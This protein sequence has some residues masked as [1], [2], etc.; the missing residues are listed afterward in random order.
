MEFNFLIQICTD[1]HV[2][3]CSSAE[4]WWVLYNS[5]CDSLL[6]AWLKQSEGS[7]MDLC[8]LF[9][10]CLCSSIKHNCKYLH[11]YVNLCV[12]WAVSYNLPCFDTIC[13]AL[14]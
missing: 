11:Y 8:G 6:S 3:I 10:Q 2:E 9:Y 5:T 4:L 7:W 14:K 12:L 13:C 1:F